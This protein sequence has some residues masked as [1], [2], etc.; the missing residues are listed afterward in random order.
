MLAPALLPFICTPFK[1]SR[2]VP[3]T[4]AST[5][6]KV[7]DSAHKQQAYIQEWLRHEIVNFP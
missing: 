2:I 1:R 7:H 5:H 3:A 4:I 6:R